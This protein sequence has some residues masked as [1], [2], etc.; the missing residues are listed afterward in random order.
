MPIFIY[1]YI[2]IYTVMPFPLWIVPKPRT[3]IVCSL[4]FQGQAPCPALEP[5]RT[6]NT[7]SWFWHN[8]QRKCDQKLPFE[9]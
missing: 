3:C 5:Q 4:R 6:D 1:A 2:Y 7:G 9:L 8:P